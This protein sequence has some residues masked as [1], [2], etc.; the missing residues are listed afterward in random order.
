MI[1]FF[2]VV[3]CLVESQTLPQLPQATVDVSRPTPLRQVRVKD[4]TELQTAINNAKAG[5]EILLTPGD[6]L[7]GKIVFDYRTKKRPRYAGVMYAKQNGFVFK[8][9]TDG[10]WVILRTDVSY[11]VGQRIDRLQNLAKLSWSTCTIGFCYV[12]WESDHKGG[13]YG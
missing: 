3:I 2:L 1:F 13:D 5:D 6:Q 12:L 11:P 9:R 7:N 4:A 8:P 10:G